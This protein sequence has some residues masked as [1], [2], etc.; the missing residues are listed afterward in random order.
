MVGRYLGDSQEGKRL[1][2]EID[3]LVFERNEL[4]QKVHNIG[5]LDAIKTNSIIK[6]TQSIT[7]KINSIQD[8]ISEIRHIEWMEESRRNQQTL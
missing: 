5:A 8:R 2:F 6:Q 4:Y 7:R 3:E 1:Q